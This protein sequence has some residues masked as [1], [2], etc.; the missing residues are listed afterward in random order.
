[1]DVDEPRVDI[2]ENTMLGP[3]FEDFDIPDLAS[4]SLDLCFK[5]FPI[6]AQGADLFEPAGFGGY[7][8]HLLYHEELLLED[9]EPLAKQFFFRLKLTDHSAGSVIR[10]AR[11]SRVPVAVEVAG[12]FDAG[13]RIGGKFSVAEIGWVGQ[14]SAGGA[15]MLRG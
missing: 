14:V 10:L 15:A 11:R 2:L 3:L 7:G 6:S 5:L 12:R 13:I 4:K 1:M 9:N 8:G